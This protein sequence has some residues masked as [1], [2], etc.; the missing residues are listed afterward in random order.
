MHLVSYR[1]LRSIR[2]DA[3]PA[4]ISDAAIM[5]ERF[6]NGRSIALKNGCRR[7]VLTSWQRFGGV[8]TAP[9]P[10]CGDRPEPK[11]VSPRRRHGAERDRAASSNVLGVF[12]AV[13]S[14]ARCAIP[15]AAMGDKAPSPPHP[16]PLP[17]PSACGKFLHNTYNIS[18]AAHR[19]DRASRTAATPPSG[20]SGVARKEPGI[21][22][23]MHSGL[24]IHPPFEWTVDEHAR[25]VAA[26]EQFGAAKMTSAHAAW[27]AIAAAVRS[28]SVAEIKAHAEQYLERLQEAQGGSDEQWTP[29][30]DAVFEQLLAIYSN[31]ATNPASAGYPWADMAAQMPGKTPQ[32]LRQRY[33][34]LCD[35]ISRIERGQLFDNNRERSRTLRKLSTKRSASGGKYSRPTLK[36]AG[37]QS[38][39][40]LPALMSPLFASG[41]SFS[42]LPLPSPFT[43]RFTCFDAADDGD[44]SSE[45]TRGASPTSRAASMAGVTA[46]LL[47]STPTP[48]YHFPS[49]MFFPPP[50][51][52]FGLTPNGSR[53]PPTP[54][55]A[56]SS[57][58]PASSTFQEP[59][60]PY[61]S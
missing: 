7:K 1:P 22:T 61:D 36:A 51:S 39:E 32:A 60:T 16:P 5:L 35:D 3:T 41:V 31:V 9:P 40:S 21:M 20:S 57:S 44:T 47:M 54:S 34:E 55:T 17:S 26:L 53:L 49:P 19:S 6:P 13:A 52:P 43:P 14:R 4:S 33:L 37:R 58:P 23:L 25:F 46:Q 50:P 56:A 8:E 45:M 10:C 48:T 30:Q 11:R 15:P 38:V 24:S 42:F 18:T 27:H 12:Q 2:A 29:A 28:R 59:T